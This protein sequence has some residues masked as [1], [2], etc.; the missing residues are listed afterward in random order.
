MTT[1]KS[2]DGTDFLIYI[3][4]TAVAY[5]TN[6]SLSLTAETRETTTKDNVDGFKSSSVTKK[7]GTCSIEGLTAMDPTI[8]VE[9]LFDYW[10]Q[11][12][13]VLVKFSNEET[14]DSRWQFTAAITNLEL[15]AP[16]Y[17]NS[18]YSCTLEVDGL[19]VKIANS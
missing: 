6:G 7:S 19:V 5:S 16:Q 1:A 15:A 4:G 10:R 13:K 9:E 8:G 18:T 2:I 3:A 11:G 17:D 12:S 14:G